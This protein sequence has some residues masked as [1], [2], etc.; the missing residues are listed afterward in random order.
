M[1]RR[2]LF[3]LTATLLCAA[4][5]ARAA[6]PLT[7]ELPG[8]EGAG[9][10][11]HIVLLAGD[12][13]YRSEEALPML[14]G[15]LSK[16]HGF[17]CTV[18]F[19]VGKDGTIDPNNQKS[20]TGSAA[21]DTADAIIMSLRFRN[22]PNEDMRR[23][24]DAFHRGVPI[25]ALRTSTHAFNFDGNSNFSRFKFDVGGG[26]GKQVLGETWVTHWGGH[27]SEATRGIIEP[28]AKDNPVLRGVTDIFGDTDVYEAHPP[29]DVTI[30][31]RG[32][33]LKGMKP[34]SPPASYKKKPVGGRP[35]QDVNDPMQPVVWLREHKN[36]EGKVNRC[37][38]T[39]MGSATDL[40]SE[41]LRRLV[42]NGVYWGLKMEVP[43]AADVT[44]TGE[45]NPT[46]YGFGGGKKGVKPADT[47][48]KPAK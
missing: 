46:M 23:F 21:L 47:A 8:G 31:V 35:E 45:Y 11:K 48:L 17:K 43:A 26:F 22:W 42:V 30:L 18:L 29:E 40:K 19:S 1:K 4:S 10:G 25:V 41:G 39:T 3:A 13:E 15:I 32:Q 9:K 7:L 37:L 6:D 16:H 36:E 12:E 14:A 33:V 5:A 28:G 27:K 2:S 24:V 20:L 34:D 38:T 44:L